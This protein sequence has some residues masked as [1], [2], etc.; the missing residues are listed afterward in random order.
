MASILD[1]FRRKKDVTTE[2]AT[3]VQAADVPDFGGSRNTIPRFAQGG[4]GGSSSLPRRAQRELML[5]EETLQTASLDKMIDILS[6]AHPDVGFAIWNFLRIGNCDFTVK[7]FKIGSDKE[8]TASNKLVQQFIQTLEMPNINRFE[9]SRSLKK[10]VNQLMLSVLTRGA[11]SV[12]LVLANSLTG[13]AFFA[14]IDPAT[15]TFKFEDDRFVPYQDT[16]KISLDIPTFIYETLDERIDEPYGRSPLTTAVQMVLFQLQVLQDIKAVVH[17]QGYPRFDITI[18]EEVLLQRMPIGIRNNEQKKSEWLRDK[19]NEVIDM[20]NGLQPDDTFVH[21]DSIKMDMVGGKGGG[22]L[23]DPE[24]LMTVIDNQI[25]AG[26]KTLSTILGRRSTGNTESFAKLEVKLYMAGVRAI[27]EVVERIMSRAFTIMLNLNG[28]QGIAQFKF[29]PIEIRTELEQEQ[30]NQIRLQNIAYKRDQGWIDQ[31]T[32]SIEATGTPAVAEPNK[33]MLG[34]SGT[35]SEG[36][37]PQANPDTTV[38][39]SSST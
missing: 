3:K 6:D 38:Q 5:D 17:N 30:F 4:G 16:D 31:D 25:M 22:T 28:K 33:E 11:G 13:V 32:A 36:G 18:L 26:L 34:V 27:Q 21:Y 35:T 29:Q 7:V 8:D 15:V 24:K 39:D 10:V 20:Y 37:T 1:F 2:F 12:E 9:S 19:L 14:P 23:I